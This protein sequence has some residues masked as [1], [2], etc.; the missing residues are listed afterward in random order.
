MSYFGRNNPVILDGKHAVTRKYVEFIHA[1]TPH[2]ERSITLA[3]I[4]GSGV[5]IRGGKIIKNCVECARLRKKP[6]E[7]LMAHLPSQ[8][9][10]GTHPFTHMGAD[11]FGPFTVI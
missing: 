10:K 4:R 7:Q 8:R 9:S 5:V 3:I 11:V 6:C 2:Q 1:E